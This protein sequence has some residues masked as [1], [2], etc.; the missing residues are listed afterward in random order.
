MYYPV[1]E[2]KNDLL[3]ERLAR[4]I[5]GLIILTGIILLITCTRSEAHE[6]PDDRLSCYGLKGSWIQENELVAENGMILETY[7]HEVGGTIQI[8]TFSI[9]LP[10]DQAVE[11]N[12][13]ESP[14]LFYMVDGDGDGEFDILLIDR[15][16]TGSCVSIVPDLGDDGK[17]YF[18]DTRKEI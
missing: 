16:F 11:G 12:S 2:D 6:L 4:A 9:P 5:V 15:E 17:E 7:A 8:M 14:P 3:V 13:H 10:I 18:T 1:R